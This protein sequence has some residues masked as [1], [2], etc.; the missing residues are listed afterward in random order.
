M[1]TLDWIEKDLRSN[2]ARASRAGRWAAKMEPRAAAAT[3]RARDNS[4]LIELTNGAA[5]TI[6]VKL[7]PGLKRAARSDV[8]S[9]EVLGRGGGL[10][11]EG[12]DL[13]LSV[14]ALVSS[15]FA[16]PE[17]MAELGRIGGTRSSAAKAAAARRNGRKGG[18]PRN[19][20]AA[21][22]SP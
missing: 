9:V 5:V 15:V 13:D 7:I 21:V 2:Y 22:T 16:G 3:Y 18:R 17:W 20:T 14:P 6:P 8:R 4:L 10:H 1:A 11:W 12:L 19:R